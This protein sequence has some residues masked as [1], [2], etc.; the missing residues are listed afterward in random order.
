MALSC[1]RFPFVTA[2]QSMRS[3]REI[4]ERGD[5][6][7]RFYESFGVRRESWFYQQRPTGGTDVVIGVTDVEEPVEPKAAQYA[8]DDRRFPDRG[9]RRTSYA[10][11][12]VDPDATPLGPATTLVYDS[13]GGSFCRDGTIAG[14]H[15]SAEE[16]RR[17][18]RAAS[19][20]L[21]GE[22]EGDAQ[23]LRSF[24][25][26]RRPG[27]CRRR[28]RTVRDRRGI[29]AWRRRRQREGVRGIAAIRSRSGSSSASS[30]CR[31]SI[32]T[33]RRWDRRARWSSS[34]RV[35]G[36]ALASSPADVAA[37]RAATWEEGETR[38]V[39]RF[40]HR[41]GGEDA[42]RSAAETAALHYR[43][44]YTSFN[45]GGSVPSCPS[46]SF[47]SPALTMACPRK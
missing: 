12:G 23:L 24:E 20:E 2:P 6:A 13:T 7:R 36:G 9:S 11:S 26:E 10:L 29:D 22:I 8:D 1:V 3:C 16:R 17:A 30:T 37:S 44:G 46:D 31:A 34:S 42:A 45:C 39:E 21:S 35:T 19:S 47:R 25:R 38:A 40:L 41:P 43:S 18:A 28:R 33:R 32:R 15:V 4:R 5:E 27:S 14:A